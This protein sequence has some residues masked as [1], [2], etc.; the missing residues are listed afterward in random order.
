[1]ADELTGWQPDPFGAHEFRFFSDDGKATLLVRDG[2]ERSYDP[3]PA[4]GFL[5]TPQ[6]RPEPEAKVLP[7]P[8]LPR[9]LVPYADR[10]PGSWDVE[11]P[12]HSRFVKGVYVVVLAAMAASAVALLI[13]HLSPH[14]SHP[15]G[16]AAATT[17]TTTTAAATTTVPLPPAPQPTAA[18]AAAALISSWAAGNQAA[19]L[20]VASA[21]AVTMLF[22]RQYSSGLVIDRGCSVA[23]SPIHCTYGPPGGAPPTDPIYQID[24]VQEPGGWY[25]SSVTINN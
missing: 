7:A 22:A 15:H 8:T 10:D 20:S 16:A 14:K 1:M 18:A 25:V 4:A 9:E 19:A 23:F 3:P 24:V 13:V 2:D 5:R 21:P 6:P 11:V 17:T 12:P